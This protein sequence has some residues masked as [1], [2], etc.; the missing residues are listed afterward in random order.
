MSLDISPLL[1]AIAR[2]QEGLHPPTVPLDQRGR[3][4]PQT[5]EDL[6]ASVELRQGA[7]S[8][9]LEQAEAHASW[10]RV[11]SRRSKCRQTR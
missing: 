7:G 6:R 9:T 5:G 1:N 3:I 8:S 10:T 4:E 11:S 2:L